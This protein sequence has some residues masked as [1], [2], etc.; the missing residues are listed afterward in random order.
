MTL[1]DFQT[2][3]SWFTPLTVAVLGGVVGYIL[4][5][6][7]A[8]RKE[9]QD[10]AVR[11]AQDTVSRKEFEQLEKRI[12]ESNDA[13]VRSFDRVEKSLERIHER[14]DQFER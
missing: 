2:F 6:I 12:T 11:F 4:F 5:E 8:L 7:R 14:I 9:H 10:S 3:L 13:V 1:T